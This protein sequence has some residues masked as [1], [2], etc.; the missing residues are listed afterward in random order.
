[1]TK[2]NEIDV[3]GAGLCGS[4]L[5]VLLARRGL[6]VSLW[7]RQADPREKSLAG[8]R[9]INLALASRGIRA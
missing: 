2:N 5:A 8:G 7:E 3:L 9:S 1:M 6:Q 4:L